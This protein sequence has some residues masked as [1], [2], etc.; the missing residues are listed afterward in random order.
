[1]PL[2]A[3]TPLTEPLPLTRPVKPVPDIWPPEMVTTSVVLSEQVRPK[4]AE[5]IAVKVAAATAAAAWLRGRSL[6]GLRSPAAVLAPGHRLVLLADA[7][8]G[9]ALRL[10][11]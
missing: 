8:A 3:Q 1:M 9:R 7:A 10:G 6:A 2:P 11:W 5:S 4:L